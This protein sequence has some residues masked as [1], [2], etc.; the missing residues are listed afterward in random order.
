MTDTV[1]LW[2]GERLLIG[3]VQGALVI[4]LVWLVCRLVPRIPAAGQSALWWL[5][6]LKLVLVFTPV[7]AVPVA[8]L[9]A[10]FGQRTERLFLQ[11]AVH[12][13]GAD[14]PSQGTP[15]RVPYGGS[16]D[17]REP[18]GANSWP[19]LLVMLWFAILLVQAGRLLYAHRVLRAIVNRSTI[20]DGEETR[21][22][23]ERLG[24]TRVP[25]VRLS[26][27]I[28]TPQV[29]GLRNPV[30]LVPAE[31]MANFTA[32]ERRMTLC[33]ELMHIRRRDLVLGWVP[34]CAERL[35]FFHPLARLTAREYIDARESACDAAAVRVLDVSAGDYGQMLVRLGI[36]HAGPALAAG[37]SPFSASSLKRRL[38]MLERQDAPVSRRWWLALVLVA[39][40][41]IPMRLVA[42]TPAPQLPGEP[43]LERELIAVNVLMDQKVAE[44]EEAAE[45]L[46]KAE[47]T[48]KAQEKQAQQLTA[49]QKMIEATAQAEAA[50]ARAAENVHIL[51]EQQAEHH[52]RMLELMAMAREN[53]VHHDT[54]HLV[55]QL[56]ER[57]AILEEMRRKNLAGHQETLA[58]HYR[59]LAEHYERLA[60]EQRKLAEELE[61]L[62]REAAPGQ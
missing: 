25:Q 48:L 45:H 61:R 52:R 33:H 12:A 41:V 57:V 11:Q 53:A 26:D 49:Q 19:Q 3:S 55:T 9:P 50:R 34:A 27:E 21:Q 32:E 35:F 22:L 18:I 36:G 23:A 4:A 46:K 42:R 5:A 37:G 6:A 40:V 10:D 38:H 16:P 8:L 58:R 54:P 1:A 44:I 51:H 47:A 24:L 20:W 7:P 29:C 59:Q 17:T 2:L 13:G 56:R 39:A 28:D 43:Q 62:Q 14:A 31:T 15:E 60:V 30:V